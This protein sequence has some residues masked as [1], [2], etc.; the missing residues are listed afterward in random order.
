MTK[1]S[2]PGSRFGLALAAAAL[3][4]L[5]VVAVP[6]S[7]AA[8]VT[9]AAFENAPIGFGAGTTGGA[10]GSTVTVTSASALASAVADNTARIVRVSGTFTGTSVVK[11]GSNKTII[12]VGANA[13]LVGIELSI[14]NHTNVIIRN[15]AISK[16][17]ANDGD[18]IHIQNAATHIWVD[19]NDLSSDLT[20]GKDFYDGLLDITH[21]GDD[22]TVSWNKFHDHFKV[23][24]VGHSDSN[25]SEDTGHLHVTYSHNWFENVNSRLP[26][27]RFGTGHAYNNFFDNVSDSAVHSR[28]N[29][30]FLA[31]NNVF[32]NTGTCITTTGDS[33]VDG[34]VNQSG[35]DFG[36]CT[37]DI[38]RTGSFTNPPYS[39]TLDQTSTVQS[40][41]TAGAGVGKVS[42]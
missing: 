36:G 10:G 31:Q 38:T 35:N 19:H 9:P 26:S 4:A 22:V 23:S 39:F 41:V 12:G 5:A 28:E 11:I 8:A 7:S 34:F 1:T 24:L 20:H 14:N 18:A 40:E 29:A 30:Q 13:G 42:G 16:V 33:P 2:I 32:R 17:S 25:G 6:T 37:N 15:L 21:A 27:L 3:G